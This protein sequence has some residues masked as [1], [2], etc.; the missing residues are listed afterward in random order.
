MSESTKQHDTR[1]T[2][3]DAR[4]ASSSACRDE[5]LPKLTAITELLELILQY[6]DMRT[7]LTSAQRVNKAWHRVISTSPPIQRAL[8]FAPSA[9]GTWS[10]RDPTAVPKERTRGRGQSQIQDSGIR[11]NPQVASILRG[12]PAQVGNEPWQM[13]RYIVDLE[14]SDK[15]S[16]SFKHNNASWRRM[17]VQQDPP[18]RRVGLYCCEPDISRR[19]ITLTTKLYDVTECLGSSTAAAGGLTIGAVF[20]MCARLHSDYEGYQVSVRPK[21]V[22]EPFTAYFH[23]WVMGQE[24]CDEFD[25]EDEVDLSMGIVAEFEVLKRGLVEAADLV[26]EVTYFGDERCADDVYERPPKYDVCLFEP[27]HDAAADRLKE[28]ARGSQSYGI[29]KEPGFL[30]ARRHKEHFPAL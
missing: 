10:T 6:L 17:L 12:W 26:L 5:V 13:R 7:L 11:F 1:S 27:G 25:I 2:W 21:W 29:T 20:D 23:S 4:R 3:P 8:F 18:V 22:F 14:T 9:P 16:I 30:W 24:R 28:S 15:A 19:T